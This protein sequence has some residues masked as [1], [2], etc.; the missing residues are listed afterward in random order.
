MQVVP[1]TALKPCRRPPKLVLQ[2]KQ[3]VCW[4]FQGVKR[5]VRMHDNNTSRLKNPHKLLHGL[6]SVGGTGYAA[7]TAVHAYDTVKAVV[8][9]SFQ[10]GYIIGKQFCQCWIQPGRSKGQL[11]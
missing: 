3:D 10:A 5:A 4:L 8:P 6:A 11:L 9:Y 2:H 7:Q 1:V